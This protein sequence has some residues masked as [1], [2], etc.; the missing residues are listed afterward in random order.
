MG[1]VL[2]FRSSEK[3]LFGAAELSTGLDFR[4][5]DA[6]TAD[7]FTTGEFPEAG[8]RTPL[9]CVSLLAE[10]FLKGTGRADPDTVLSPL[11]LPY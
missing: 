6:E 7:S 2:V 3:G 5:L 9:S 10:A 11:G 1:A 8:W 4:G